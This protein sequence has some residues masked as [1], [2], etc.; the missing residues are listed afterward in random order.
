MENEKR[1]DWEKIDQIFGKG[2]RE[3]IANALTSDKKVERI[4]EMPKTEE[5]FVVLEIT[6]IE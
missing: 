3:E 6:M 1:R 5:Q 2:S 4:E